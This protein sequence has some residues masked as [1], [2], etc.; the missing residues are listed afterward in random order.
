MNLLY[1]LSVRAAVSAWPRTTFRRNQRRPV[2]SSG[3]ALCRR[4]TC[5]EASGCRRPAH[6]SPG[7]RRQAGLVA[8]RQ[9]SG[10]CWLRKGAA[11]RSCTARRRRS[12]HALGYEVVKGPPLRFTRTAPRPCCSP[13]R[14][15][16]PRAVAQ[17]S[18]S[19]LRLASE[20]RSPL[21]T[22]SPWG[23]SMERG[24]S[25]WGSTGGKQYGCD[26][27]ENTFLVIL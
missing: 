18:T 3:R 1:C 16:A 6:C 25:R 11:R 17:G 20:W 19:G 4:Q 27:G 5:R 14:R 22:V 13:R 26:E 9:L 21:Q 24:W 15:W 10:P 12:C 7:R 8:R 2:R 23:S